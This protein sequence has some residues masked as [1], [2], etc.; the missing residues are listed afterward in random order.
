[1]AYVL[2]MI[3]NPAAPAAGDAAHGPLRKLFPAGAITELARGVA[4]ELAMDK[5]DESILLAARE[6]CKGLA[7]DI[8]LVRS[9]NRRK[10]LLIAD[11]DST[12]IGQECIDE[13]ADFAGKREEI[14][15]ITERAM[16]GE[17][18]FEAALKA[19]VAMLK[20]LPVET[21]EKTYNER[22][23]L[24]PG[25]QTLVRTMNAMGAVTALV[26]GGFTFFVERIATAAG[27]QHSFA[28][29][30]EVARG[31]LTGRVIEPILGRTAKQNALLRLT[32]E[33]E[34]RLADTLAVGDGAN[35]LAMLERAGLGVAYRAKPA[36][37]QTARAR[38]DH[39][40]LTA[41]LYLQGIPQSE[42]V[43]HSS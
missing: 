37:A 27:F 25:A 12:I 36:V 17:L 38:I 43:M 24:R 8:N 42:F 40:D 13:L 16:R 29:E 11:M 28:N 20:G 32:G 5:A 19:R 35:D 2:S 26:S 41:L 21:L 7:V 4:Y 33:H 22:I 34:L 39:G 14:S 1:M 31:V 23:R 3:A 6:A 15:A 10:R 30:L 18:D 9:D